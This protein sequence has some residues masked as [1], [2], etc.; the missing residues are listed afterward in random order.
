MKPLRTS[1]TLS[2]STK[3]VFFRCPADLRAWFTEHQA[4]ARELWVGYWKKNSGQPS[5]TYPESLDEALCVGW[6]DG[7]RKGLDDRRYAIRFTPRKPTS[8]WSAVNIKRAHAL[9]DA[10]R[11]Q[12]AGL[13]AFHPQRE[14]KSGAY[15]YEHRPAELPEPYASLLRKTPPAWMFFQNQP[16][17]YR[18]AATWW[19]ISARKEETRLERLRKLMC[20][21]VQE[22]RLNGQ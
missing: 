20:L 16:P 12:P 11:L 10:G 9:M 2:P 1:S 4:S 13:K 21:S 5:V 19:V 3:P 15:S 14:N 17:S 8:I 6:I 18:K 7:L 22:R